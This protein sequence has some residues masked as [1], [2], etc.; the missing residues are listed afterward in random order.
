MADME[1]T[2][3]AI[4]NNPQMMQNILTMAQS[5][6]KNTEQST[7]TALPEEFDLGIL[8]K[9]GSLSGHTGI[10]PQ[11]K[12]LLSAL[13]P[14]LTRSRTAKLE[15]AMRAAKMAKLASTFLGR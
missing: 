2:L 4:L 7:E 11:Q 10:D 3:N 5:I 6:G 14:Y 15:K 1:D 13:S 8:Q 12:A 9:I